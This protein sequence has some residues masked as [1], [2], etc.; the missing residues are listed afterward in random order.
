MSQAKKVI[1]RLLVFI[2]NLL[3]LRQNKIFLY[4]YYGSQYS[5]NPKYISEYIRTHY[6]RE[7]FNLVWAFN[8]LE[9]APFL[10]H[11]RKVK[12]MSLRYFYELCTAKVII[13]NY[14]TTD[15]FVKRK[16]Q[17][18]VQTWHSSLRLKQIEKDAQQMLPNSYV[19]MAKKDARKCDLLLSGC[20]FSTF[21]FRRAFWHKGEIME[22]GTP[23]NDLFFKMNPDKHAAIMR[24]LGLSP[25]TKVLLYAPT[26]RKEEV[27]SPYSLPTTALLKALKRRFGGDWK[28]LVKLHPHVAAKGDS[29]IHQEHTVNVSDYNDIQEL[30][31]VADVVI[32]DYS[33]L[34][35]DFA[36]TK[37]PCLLYVPDVARYMQKERQLYFQL[38]EL[39]FIKATNEQELVKKIEQMQ[40]DIYR[41]QVEAFLNEIGSFETGLASAQIMK[42][43]EQV[44]FGTERVEVNEAI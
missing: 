10:P 40:I 27:A 44:C 8:R 12:V 30:L 43:I 6:P 29:V 14:R 16:D 23:R 17:Y 9:Q 20:R 37:R 33:S 24:K 1:A 19:D 34:I 21:I 11:A 28:L 42:R 38:D 31:F 32:S 25:E 36:L 7:T 39:P 41:K 35:F 5:C 22:C 3:P 4:S 13:T 26:F 2:F 15:V 18:Y